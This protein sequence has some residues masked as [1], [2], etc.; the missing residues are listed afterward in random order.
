MKLFCSL[1]REH[2]VK[3]RAA[4]EKK[5]IQWLIPQGSQGLSIKCH[6]CR[7][8][9]FKGPLCDEQKQISCVE[10]TLDE[11]ERDL[12]CPPVHVY[13]LLLVYQRDG[14]ALVLM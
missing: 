5:T 6:R 14:H 2:G 9:F 13:L 10:K 8:P 7:V 3:N 12:R 1:R 4:E 11:V